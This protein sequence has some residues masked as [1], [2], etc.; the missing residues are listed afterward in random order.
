MPPTLSAEGSDLVGR[1]CAVISAYGYMRLFALVYESMSA[2]PEGYRR[3]RG[4]ALVVGRRLS[5]QKIAAGSLFVAGVVCEK[6]LQ[7]ARRCLAYNMQVL[8]WIA[9]RIP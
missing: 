2:V 8:A 4:L 3:S 7:Q 1:C 6:V 9:G 5:R